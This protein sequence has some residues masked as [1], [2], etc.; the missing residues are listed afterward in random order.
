[1]TIE[2]AIKNAT[3]SVEMEG[4]HIDEQSKEWCRKLLLGIITQDEYISLVIKKA[5]AVAL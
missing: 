1:M 4:Y 3:V 5:G 2:Q